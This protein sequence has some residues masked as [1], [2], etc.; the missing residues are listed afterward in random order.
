MLSSSSD[1][2]NNTYL[3]SIEYKFRHILNFYNNIYKNYGSLRKQSSESYNKFF[4]FNN[5][6]RLHKFLVHSIYNY[7]MLRFCNSSCAHAVRLTSLI[8]YDRVT[9]RCNNF[10]YAVVVS[11]LHRSYPLLTVIQY[12]FAFSSWMLSYG[13][14]KRPDS[15]NLTYDRILVASACNLI[16]LA[17]V[18][19]YLLHTN[20][21]TF[22]LH[23]DYFNL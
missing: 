23:F 11:I 4:I 8:C 19:F 10:S 5:S 22:R 18:I 2:N 20:N 15:Y 6:T 16:K 14:S 17:T 12:C 3:I 21:D 1:N 9:R 13:S 7:G